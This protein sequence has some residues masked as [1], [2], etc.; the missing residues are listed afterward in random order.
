MATL[1]KLRLGVSDDPAVLPPNL[2]DC[3]AA[4]LQHAEVLMGEVLTGL[5]AAASPTGPKKQA[6]FQKE[7][8]QEVV[9]DLS[10]CSPAV[11]ATYK[12]ELSRIVYE[13]GGKEVSQG[14]ALRY[15]DL[16]L[17]GDAELDQSIE[18]ARAQQEVLLCVDDALPG[19][20]ALISTLM[21]WRTIQSGL[22]PLR[23]DVFVR[24]FQACLSEHVPDARVRE[25][26]LAPSA[27]LLGV[28]LRKLYRE[29]S[30]WLRSSGI[31]PAVPVGGKLY[32]GGGATG[33]MASDSVAKTLLTLDRLRHLLAGD[34]DDPKPKDDML[35][36]PAS[37]AMLQ[38]MKQVDALVQ[39][40]EKRPPKSGQQEV[41]M[42]ERPAMAADDAVS[43]R[44]GRQLGHEV[45]RLMFDNLAQDAR[46]MTEFKTQL[47][48]MEQAVFTLAQHDSRFFS[49]RTHPA[50]QFLDRITQRS[51]AFSSTSDEGWRRFLG[52]VQ[53]AVAWLDSKVVD[54]EV[55]GELMDN[56]QN[57]WGD[58][59]KVLHS[60]RE[61]A[62]RALLHA[63]QRNLLAQKLADEFAKSIDQHE[64]APFAADFLKGSWAQVVADAQLSCADGS[65]DPY[66][67]RAV[68]PQLIWS[69]QKSV[70]TRGRNK[71]LAQMIPGLLATLR[72][73][74]ARIHYP[75]ELTAHFF[76]KL[77]T[78]HQ[79][80]LDAGE[81]AEERLRQA[82]KAAEAG[83][84]AS[85]AQPGKAAEKVDL[86]PAE[87]EKEDKDASF[88]DSQAAFNVEV[89]EV[90]DFP[91]L[92]ALPPAGGEAEVVARKEA[93][94]LDDQEAQES[95]YLDEHSYLPAEAAAAPCAAAE[96]MAEPVGA[97]ELS[98]G[99]WLELMLNGMWVR[100]Q[101]TWA[102]PHGTLFMFTSLSGSAHSMSRRTLERLRGQGMM[103]VVAERN[104][105]DDA[106]DQ[107][108]KAA[109]NNSLKPRS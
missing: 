82:A 103:K 38:D 27:G 89:T 49:D 36:V 65:D 40:L 56:L 18:V 100:V 72:E 85:T 50:R 30:D 68:V 33:K 97:A 20:D 83:R 84:R 108:A 23:P 93:P 28:T 94:Y 24:A 107:V 53:D 69:V 79:A 57:E 109:L 31:E 80:T 37:M 104:V 1:L 63:E 86:A 98:T 59:D 44:L 42:L 41:D 13:G 91:P 29:L 21:G 5:K 54:A 15:E 45:V 78:L 6:A 99:T 14:E 76:E 77:I 16:Q 71:R 101:L 12:A 64:L 17:F 92:P 88:D 70:G 73:G 39:R 106:L 10:A 51:L 74:L 62:A 47:K 81:L 26:L 52:T 95:G 105:V 34:F 32:K 60:R 67:Y 35:T 87:E 22:N 4:M 48:A 75:P 3:L 9:R 2:N 25:A 7:D 61:E 66:G 55:F 46:L 102:S 43:P 90:F 58:H 96:E 11:C 8:I 19:L